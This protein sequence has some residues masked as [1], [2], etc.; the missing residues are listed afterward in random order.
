MDDLIEW[1]DNMYQVLC[2][3]TARTQKQVDT[4]HKS[5]VTSHKDG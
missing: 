3:H 4:G 1:Y 2:T 5:Q